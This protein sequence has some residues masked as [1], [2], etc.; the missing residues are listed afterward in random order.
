MREATL[1]D[2]T[3]R[4]LRV[5]LHIQQHLEDDLSLDDLAGIAAFSPYH[6]HRIFRGMVGES[7]RSHVRRLRLERA[8]TQLKLSD[9]PVTRIALEAGYETH[10]SFTRAF[11]EMFGASP[12][13]FRAGNGAGREAAAPSGIHYRPD[14]RLEDFEPLHTGGKGMKVKIVREKPVR[15]A[16]V[17]HVGP[18][19]QC[20]SAWEKLC[21]WAGPRGYLGAGTRFLGLCHD[22]PEITPPERIRYDACIT[23]DEAFDAEGEIGVQTIEGGDYAMTTHF[24][25]YDKLGETYAM[26]L[27][28]WV[29]RNGRQVRSA[30]GFEVYYN[31]PGETDPE[32][33]VTDV[34]VPLV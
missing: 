11:R 28:Q 19:D 15:V 27:G 33:L 7:V 22:D 34:H 23:V 26:L 13:G 16:F 6:F 9:L 17:R 31:D 14:G 18:Y 30:P 12:S 8:A 1:R 10:E 29:P 32:D 21:E 20:G 3:E 2:Y 24:G 4:I 5:L 25:P